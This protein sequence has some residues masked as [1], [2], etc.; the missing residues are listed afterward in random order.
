MGNLEAYGIFSIYSPT[1]SFI[2]VQNSLNV[3]MIRSLS[4]VSLE[5]FHVI[6]LIER[7][8]K[9]DILILVRCSSVAGDLVFTLGYEAL[10]IRSLRH[11]SLWT[12]HHR[13]IIASS[14]GVSIASSQLLEAAEE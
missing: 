9:Q 6:F 2:F 4:T 1:T 13:M 12:K 7:F 8:L 3:R 11:S 10:A 5:R 14:H